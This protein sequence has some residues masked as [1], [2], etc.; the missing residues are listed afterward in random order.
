MKVLT[1]TI[2]ILGYKINQ[3]QTDFA[4]VYSPLSH[5]LLVIK[6]CHGTLT[7]GNQ[8]NKVAAFLKSENDNKSI[9]KKILKRILATPTVIMVKQLD[10]W[11]CDYVTSFAPYNHLFNLDMIV[12]QVIISIA[13]SLSAKLQLIMLLYRL[14]T[15]KIKNVLTKVSAW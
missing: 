4:K 14:I 1:G 11:Q 7:K 5:S 6:E 10:D 13:F 9:S 2:D 12:N 8:I 3:N 15:I